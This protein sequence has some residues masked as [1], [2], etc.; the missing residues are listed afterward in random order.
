MTD[1]ALAASAITQKT[2]PE[3]A[4]G[5]G[6]LGHERPAPRPARPHLRHP[7]RGGAGRVG[8]APGRP[9]RRLRPGRRQPSSSWWRR[10]RPRCGTRSAP[11]ARSPRSWPRS[12]PWPPAGRTAATCRS[13]GTRCRLNTALRYMT[14][15]SMASQRAQRAFLAHR[16]AKR[17]GLLLPEPTALPDAANENRTN[18]NVG[19]GSEVHERIAARRSVPAGRRC[20]PGSTGCS[21]VLGPDRGR[22]MGSGGR[23]PGRQAARCRSL[24]RRAS[25]G[26]AR[27]AADRAPLRRRRP[28]LA[29]R[30][31]PPGRTAGARGTDAPR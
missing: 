17:D 26:P 21:T 13:P 4:R 15:A 16:K 5:Q 27:P 10:S 8:A 28:R 31:Q 12:R 9:A 20:A 14:A 22:G 7:A 30:L 3:H 23:H 24:S 11:T 6:A 2:R 25:T 18:E 1:A 29:R 19:R